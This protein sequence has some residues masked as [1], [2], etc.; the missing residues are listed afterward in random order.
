[1][2]LLKIVMAQLDINIVRVGAPN[3]FLFFFWK[4]SLEYIHPLSSPAMRVLSTIVY[5][6]QKATPRYG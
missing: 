2:T 3:L 4:S 1:M 5:G 6:S